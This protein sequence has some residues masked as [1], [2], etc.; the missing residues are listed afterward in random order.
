MQRGNLFAKIPTRLSKE[1][2]QPLVEHR[3]FRLERILSDGQ[4]TPEG[5]WYDQAQDEWVVLLQGSAELLFRDPPERLQMRPGDY[6]LIPAH[7]RHRVEW[8]DAKE[9]TVWLAL[10]FEPAQPASEFRRTPS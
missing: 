5:E 2:F 7:R 1:I 8:T 4:S 6:V 10:H 9:K 3:A